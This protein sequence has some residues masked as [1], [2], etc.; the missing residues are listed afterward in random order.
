MILL[1][2]LS[3]SIFVLLFLVATTHLTAQEAPSPIWGVSPL[4]GSLLSEPLTDRNWGILPSNQDRVDMW[5]LPQSL[6]PNMQQTFLDVYGNHILIDDN[7]NIVYD[8]SGNVVIDSSSM[9]FGDTITPENLN[10]PPDPIDVPL[11]GGTT[12]LIVLAIS[13]AYKHRKLLLG[14]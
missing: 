2:R 7:G 13:L 3:T 10:I 4:E 1:N 6:N 11:D 14:I 8:D 12:I 5:G 9:H